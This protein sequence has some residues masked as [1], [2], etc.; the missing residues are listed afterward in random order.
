ME[1][2][3][4]WKEFELWNFNFN[5]LILLM[6]SCRRWAVASFVCV[7]RE[8]LFIIR[9]RAARGVGPT[10]RR[11]VMSVTLSSSARV[12]FMSPSSSKLSPAS[13]R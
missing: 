9:G 3:M 8:V 10:R 1:N 6:V 2:P 7:F 12:M 4:Y 11:Y 5:G 13:E